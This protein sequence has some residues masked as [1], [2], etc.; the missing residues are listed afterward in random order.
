MIYEDSIYRAGTFAR[1]NIIIIII[2]IIILTFLIKWFI[3]IKAE[4]ES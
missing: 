3:K 4:Q 1:K 2:L